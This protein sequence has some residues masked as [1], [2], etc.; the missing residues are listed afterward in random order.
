[1]EGMTLDDG[2]LTAPDGLRGVWFEDSEG[3]IISVS[4]MDL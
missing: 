1:M 4:N 2:V 3:N